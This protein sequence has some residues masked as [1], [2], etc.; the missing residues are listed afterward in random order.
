MDE[1]WWIHDKR[2]GLERSPN[3]ANAIPCKTRTSFVYVLPMGFLWSTFWSICVHFRNFRKPSKNT[4]S[5]S[6]PPPGTWKNNVSLKNSFSWK[7]PKCVFFLKSPQLRFS[8]NH[9]KCFF[10]KPRFPH[11]RNFLEITQMRVSEIA[12]NTLFWTSPKVRF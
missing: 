9:P 6:G 2:K 4:F 8:E 5:T 3:A 11:T 12:Q 7:S 1:T 10:L